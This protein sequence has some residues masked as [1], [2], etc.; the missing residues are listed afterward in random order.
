[1]EE[2]NRRTGRTIRLVDSYIQELYN[3]KII[4]VKDHYDHKA[5]HE[6]LYLKIRKRL[7]AEH[8]NYYISK[9][10]FDLDSLTIK[11]KE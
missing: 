8:S 10:D 11:F 3:N 7:F 5:A 9:L 4:T 1:M 2:L 6:D